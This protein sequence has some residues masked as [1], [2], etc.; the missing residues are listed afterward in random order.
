LVAVAWQRRSD[1]DDWRLLAG[2][3]EMQS[4]AWRWLGGSRLAA[5]Q[6]WPHP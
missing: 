6:R 2:L 4:F 5:P 1:A 3:S